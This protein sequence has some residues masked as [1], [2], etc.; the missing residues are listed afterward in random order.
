MKILY[1]GNKLSKHGY[2]VTNIETLGPL[3]SKEGF[4]VNYASE[5]ENKFLRLLDMCFKT[6][7][8]SPKKGF[9]IIDSYST[10][11]FLYL[12]IISQLCRILKKRY[13]P[14]LH[15][16]NLPSRLKNN[17][18][19]SKMIFGNA[20]IN[21]APSNYLLSKFKEYNFDNVI[22]IPN[23]IEIENYSFKNRNQFLPKLLWVRSF[24][25]IYNPLMAVKVL[26]ELQKN[27]PLSELCMVGPEKDGS[28]EL[29]KKFVSENNL[30]VNFTGKLAKTEWLKLSENYDIFINTTH[31]DNTPLS[32]IEAMALGLPIISTNVGGIPFLLKNNVNA[33]LV[34]DN[35]VLEMVLAIEK[36]IIN[37]EFSNTMS[38]NARAITQ[39][40]D[41][42]IVKKE[43]FKI[44]KN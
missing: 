30:K 39:N 35:Q 32:V 28:L 43:W 14:I 42:Q 33:I 36:L 4:H 5:F 19:L 22:F 11:G 38:Q 21:V 3:L 25:K 9:V 23:T 27:F 24:D 15:G 1:I 7:F 13:I 44:L 6:L 8:F 20:H 34:G 41:W 17:P 26:K 2:N 37:P 18:K 10:F 12:L 16:G 31:F 29:V 40:F